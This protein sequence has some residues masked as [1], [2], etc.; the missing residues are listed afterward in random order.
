[1]AKDYE[2]YPKSLKIVDP[3]YPTFLQEF[4]LH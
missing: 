4:R 3:F 2:E 1:M